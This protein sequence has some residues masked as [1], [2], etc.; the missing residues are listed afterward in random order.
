MP[1][2]NATATAS[3]GLRG[4]AG[5]IGAVASRDAASVS[6]R[7][8]DYQHRRAWQ[9]PGLRHAVPAKA[10]DSGNRSRSADDKFDGLCPVIR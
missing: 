6:P 9:D 4:V 7:N 1:E 10:G 5:C 2:A 8:S 3:S